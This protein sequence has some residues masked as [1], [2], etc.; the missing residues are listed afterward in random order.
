[1]S[2]LSDSLSSLIFGKQPERFAHIAHQKRGYERIA[3]FL[4]NLTYIKHKFLDFFSQ[5][6]LIYHEQPEGVAHGCSFVMSDL[7]DSLTVA[8]LP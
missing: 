3:H 6:L 7:S 1:M 8:H 2:A 5:N 4:T